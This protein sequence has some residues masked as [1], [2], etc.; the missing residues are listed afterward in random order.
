MSRQWASITETPIMFADRIRG[1]SK[2]STRIIAESM[3]LVT[4]W[5]IVDRWRSLRRSPQR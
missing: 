5:G 4:R 2:M 1:T 3:V